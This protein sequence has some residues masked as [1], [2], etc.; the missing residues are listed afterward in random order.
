[1]ERL[2]CRLSEP[3]IRAKMVAWIALMSTLDWRGPRI[4]SRDKAPNEQHQSGQ[5]EALV[6]A[7]SEI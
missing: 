6:E 7:L 1:M 5:E 4:W 2:L 3:L